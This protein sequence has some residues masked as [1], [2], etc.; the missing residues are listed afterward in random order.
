MF[1]RDALSKQN[2]QRLSAVLAEWTKSG[3]S[4]GTLWNARDAMVDAGEITCDG[5]P[6]V[7]HLISAQQ[8]PTP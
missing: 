4:E 3:G 1:I 7:L 6:K 8:H 5:K 2:D